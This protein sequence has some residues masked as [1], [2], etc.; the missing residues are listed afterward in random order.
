M[1]KANRTPSEELR[2]AANTAAAIYNHEESNPGRLGMK[3]F[4]E[5]LSPVLDGFE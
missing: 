4:A 2:N 1:R 3:F 5:L